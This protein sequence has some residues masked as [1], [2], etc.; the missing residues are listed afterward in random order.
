MKGGEVFFG[1]REAGTM[2]KK[3]RGVVLPLWPGRL[4]PGVPTR[5]VESPFEAGNRLFRYQVLLVC[6]TEFLGPRSRWFVPIPTPHGA[7]RYTLSAALLPPYPW[8]A[9]SARTTRYAAA[10]DGGYDANRP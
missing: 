8:R 4:A 5:H 7:L 10:L 6:W 2:G 3:G 1:Y 9:R